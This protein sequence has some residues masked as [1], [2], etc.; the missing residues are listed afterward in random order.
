MFSL[1]SVVF[2][3]VVLLKRAFLVLSTHL[4][5]W[6][7]EGCSVGCEPHNYR[8]LNPPR[9]AFQHSF[10]PRRRHWTRP[11]TSFFQRGID[12]F[13]SSSYTQV[14]T[15]RAQ[16]WCQSKN[17][18]PYFETSAKEAINVEQAFQTIARNA[19]KQ[20]SNC[21]LKSQNVNR[22]ATM[23]S[24]WPWMISVSLQHRW[25]TFCFLLYWSF[26]LLWFVPGD[27]GGVV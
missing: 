11:C 2:F 13:S 9:W 14:T 7:D 1:T 23:F 19:L 10:F 15:K 18:I 17:N 6:W 25:L 21:C 8:P 3:P 20:V 4:R 26:S 5:R 27:R 24:L 16:A 22:W 12:T